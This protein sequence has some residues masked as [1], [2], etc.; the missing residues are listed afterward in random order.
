MVDE[1]ELR[2]AKKFLTGYHKKL[3]W[4]VNSAGRRVG[5]CDTCIPAVDCSV[6]FAHGIDGLVS[7]SGDKQCCFF[8]GQNPRYGWG[9]V[10]WNH[11]VMDFRRPFYTLWWMDVSPRAENNF[12]LNTKNFL[13]KYSQLKIK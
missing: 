6:G 12:P 2:E 11:G 3:P 9:E 4:Q 13:D 7:E 8:R 10:V 1:R 5:H